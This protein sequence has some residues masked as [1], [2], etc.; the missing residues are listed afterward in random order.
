MIAYECSKRSMN[1]VWLV[2]ILAFPLL[3]CSLHHLHRCSMATR[4]SLYEK[5]TGRIPVLFPLDRWPF[6]FGV[7]AGGI[8][9]KQYNDAI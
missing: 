1:R 8:E 2:E 9:I 5:S 6:T 7:F 3:G 4:N